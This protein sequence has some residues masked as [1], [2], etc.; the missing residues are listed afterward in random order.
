MNCGSKFNAIHMATLEKIKPPPSGSPSSPPSATTGSSNPFP[1]EV[2][3]TLMTTAGK[4]RL[5]KPPRNPLVL[6]TIW[7][8]PVIINLAMP[9]PLLMIERASVMATEGDMLSFDTN[10]QIRMWI[11]GIDSKYGS[12]NKIE[13]FS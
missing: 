9:M 6:G 5:R 4:P 7:H 13:Y 12:E 3:M 2:A 1:T 11:W 10:R 8:C